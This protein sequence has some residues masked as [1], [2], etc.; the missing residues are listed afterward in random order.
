M[1]KKKAFESLKTRYIIRLIRRKIGRD[2]VKKTFLLH[3][4]FSIFDGFIFGII[5]LSE[6]IL[7]KSLN[8]T[9]VQVGILFQFGG[10]LLLFSFIFNYYFQ[11]TVRKKRMIRIFAFISGVPFFFTLI[12]P[13]HS[14]TGQNA[15]IFQLIFLSI[16]FFYY[17]STPIIL[18]AIN[19]L[20]KNN[21]DHYDF[22]KYFGYS[23]TINKIVMLVVTFVFGILLDFSPYIYIYIFPILGVM[24]IVSIYILTGIDYLP[25]EALPEKEKLYISLKKAMKSMFSILRLDKPFRDFEIG[26]MLYGFAWMI[27]TPVIS[28]FLSKKLNMD[29]TEI[30]FYK[31]A[32]NIVSIFLL[33]M[34]GKLLSR[35]DPRKFGIYTFSMLLLQ[36]VFIALTE[37]FPGYTTVFHIKIYYLLGISYIFYGIFGALMALLWYIGSAYFCRQSDIAEY[38][39]IHLTL[40]GV[41]GGI[42]PLLGVLFFELIDFSG[43]FLIGILLLGVSCIVLAISLKKAQIKK[44]A[45]Q[46]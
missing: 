27:T 11:Q 30:A 25:P 40:T 17:L 24:R 23:A 1:K 32:Y 22:G 4:I 6:F 33:P 16:F 21:Y 29:Y 19:I 28:I 39:S 26:F 18:P 7:L 42:A 15:F 10:I 37:F 12:F 43:V 9:N 14:V 38:Q 34:F 5:A 31:N 46:L 41:R 45:H 44:F 13:N 35:I 36:L 3:G 8:G 20:L 2:K